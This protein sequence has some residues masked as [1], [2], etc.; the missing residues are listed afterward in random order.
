MRLVRGGLWGGRPRIVP[1]GL[2]AAMQTACRKQAQPGEG[3]L[4]PPEETFADDCAT[5]RIRCGCDSGCG[6]RFVRGRWTVHPPQVIAIAHLAQDDIVVEENV[7][8][9]AGSHAFRS[10]GAGQ[11]PEVLRSANDVDHVPRSA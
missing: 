10:T 9:G 4:R 8:G 6:D 11:G 7:P 1:P 3:L 2:R 5:R